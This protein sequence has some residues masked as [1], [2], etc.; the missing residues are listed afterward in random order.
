MKKLLL[1]ASTLTLLII[2]FTFNA[3]ADNHV[4]DIDIDAALNKD[5]SAVITQVWKGSF[6]EGTECYYPFNTKGELEITDFTVS[7]E[8]GTFETLDNWDIDASFSEKARKC[9]LNYTDYGYEVCWGISEYSNNT[10]TVKYTVKNLV[11]SFDEED[12]FNFRFVN[13]EMNTGPTAVTVTISMADGTPLTDSNSDIWAFGFDGDI[14]FLNN[15]TVYAKTRSDIDSDNHVTIMCGF[16]KGV[17][18]SL[19]SRNESFEEFKETAFDGSDYETEEEEDSVFVTIVG[20]VMVLGIAI[21]FAALIISAVA[22]KKRFKK[23]E[24]ECAYFRD[25]PNNGELNVSYNLALAFKQCSESDIIGARILQMISRGNI[26]GVKEETAGA[27]GKIRETVS[28]RLV[29]PP[30][31]ENS[32]NRRLYDILSSAAGSDG[33]LQEKELSKYSE[34]HYKRLRAYLDD[35]DSDGESFL[36]NRG[37]YSKAS[38]PVTNYGYEDLRSLSENG[39]KELA[40]LIGFKK[41]LLEF[42]LI[43]EKDVN[44]SVLWQ[45]CLV[46]AVLLG[47]ADKVAEQLR[48]VYPQYIE[49][50]DN[51][52]Y[53]INYIHLYCIGMMNSVHSQE[54]Q[55]RNGGSGGSA[56]FGGGGGFS[57]GGSGGGTR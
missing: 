12:G 53:H 6:S 21:I 22:R 39:K 37:C 30:E 49:D 17:F 24:K 1:F 46:Y 5:G 2:C 57:G 7:D 50:I 26:E 9:G 33:I 18:S 35:C 32:F 45:D 20:I 52:V 29:N 8:N 15:G 55:A 56:S 42:S 28:L 43:S 11:G 3:Y 14:Q 38:I 4:S 36:I 10:Y 19:E 23:F 34:N 27:F 25:A 16:E 13:D 47:I 41:Y 40:E 31:N 54:A 51:Y 44:E 48:E